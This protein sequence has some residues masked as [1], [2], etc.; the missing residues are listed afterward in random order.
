MESR[1][2]VT[3]TEST[4]SQSAERKPRDAGNWAEGVSTL[5]VSEVPEGAVNLNVEG[6]RVA[7]PLRGF[8]A[9]WQKTYRVR[10]HGSDVT[11]AQVVEVWKANFQK[12][13]PKQNRFFPTRAGFKP[14][15]IV[16]INATMTGMPVDAGVM[17]LYADEESFTVMTP[18][19]FPEAGFNSFSAYAEDGCTVAQV[20]SIA[21][22]NDPIY[23][24]GFRIVGSRVQERIW[25]HVLT[26]LAAHF[27]VK[28]QVEM[29]KICL[30]PRVQWSQVRNVWHNASIRSLIYVIGR[31]VRIVRGRLRGRR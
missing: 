8:G 12:F 18:E 5:K 31:P 17:V 10:M 15:Q 24:L 14:G 3:D 25:A 23:E 27:G 9:L 16:L 1:R 29:E 6:R 22:A 7:G 26:S 19:G 2:A 11:P 13:Q 4:T 30:D 20:Q 21:R 28:G